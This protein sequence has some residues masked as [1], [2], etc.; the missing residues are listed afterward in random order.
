MQVKGLQGLIPVNRFLDWRFDDL[1][2][3]RSWRQ[4]LG[5][6]V[7]ALSVSFFLFGLWWPYWR[8]ADMDFWMVYEG[9]LLNDRLP[10]EWFD[11]PGYFTILLL[12]NWFRLL[13]AVGVLH[14]HALS[15]L[16]APDQAGDAWTAAVRAG[17]VLS[18][19]PTTRS[20]L[21][22]GR[23]LLFPR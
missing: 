23:F 15:E 20:R 21:G 6:T 10:Q 1:V 11:H 12:G 14:V 9:F 7:L 2:P 17:R 8:T 19:G 18:L 16:P 3:Y 5:G 13:H 22:T 4:A